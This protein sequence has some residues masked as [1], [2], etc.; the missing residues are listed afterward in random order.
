MTRDEFHALL[1]TVAAGWAN[2]DASAVAA[3]FAE[4]V[5]YLDPYR[6]RFESRTDLVPF[7]EP[8]AGG[9]HVT[10]HTILWDDTAQTGS[11]EYTY[12]G[13]HA[14]HGA[15]VAHVDGA[16]QIDAWREWQHLDDAVDWET[17]VRG[18]RPVSS[19]PDASILGSIDHVQLGMPAGG[20]E[21]ARAFFGA[22][23]GLREVAKPDEL[24]GRGGAW[25][26]ARSVA[27]HVGVEADFRPASKAHPAFTVDDLDEVRGRLAAAG[28]TTTADDSGMPVSRCYLQDPFGNRIELVD[29]RDAG[30]SAR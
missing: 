7:F 16:G 19:E 10:W 25:F 23:L 28:V 14:Y 4:R 30:F 13:H 22:I 17:R 20:E 11:V 18:P 9:H 8:P 5:D 29:A 2:G 15:A 6:Y 1:E 21:R 26:A 12:V 27:I 3:C 24:A